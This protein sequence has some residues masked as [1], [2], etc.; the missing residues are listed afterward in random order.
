MGSSNWSDDAYK[1]RATTYAHT[2]SVKGISKTDATFAYTASIR[3]GAAPKKAHDALNPFGLKM[4]ESRDSVAH[5][6]SLAIA[7]FFDVTGSMGQIPITL[8]TKLAGLMNLLVSKGYVEHPQILF[9]AIGDAT[10]DSVPLQ[11]G[12]FESGLEMDDDLTR[13]FIEGGGGGQHTETYELAHYLAARHTAIDC[14]EKR[15]Q[16]GY[17]FTIGDE[18][19]YDVVRRAHIKTLIGT[20]LQAD[21]SLEDIIAEAQQRY[22]VFHIIAEQGAYPHDAAI[23]KAWTSRLGQHVLKLEDSDNVAELIALTIGLSEGTVDLDAAGDHLKSAGADKRTI[24]TVTQALVPFA[25]AGGAMM[26]PGTLS[27][28]PVAAGAADAGP[29]RL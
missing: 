20:D 6:T 25:A 19:P 15:S 21:I 28:L 24:D 23:E 16:K 17:L 18:A 2:A 27:N 1:A 13:V 9:G 10:C 7:V 5:P 14:F 8:Q 26:K 3:S 11:I 12:Q 29:I 22:H 4:R